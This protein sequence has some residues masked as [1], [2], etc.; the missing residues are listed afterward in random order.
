LYHK[1]RFENEALWLVAEYNQRRRL[2][3]VGLTQDM[4]T[5]DAFRGEAFLIISDEIDSLE[6]KAREKAE[7]SSKRR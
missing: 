4:S 6:A 7:K 2:K 5:V 1:Q 3:A